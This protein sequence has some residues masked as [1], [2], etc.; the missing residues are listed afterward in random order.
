MEQLDLIEGYYK[1]LLGFTEQINLQESYKFDMEM[2]GIISANLTADILSL[3][4]GQK[5]ME[6]EIINRPSIILGEKPEEFEDAMKNLGKESQDLETTLNKTSEL[7]NNV[8]KNWTV[9]NDF[10]RNSERYLKTKNLKD[11]SSIFRAIWI[12]KAALCREGHQIMNQVEALRSFFQDIRARARNLDHDWGKVFIMYNNAMLKIVNDEGTKELYDKMNEDMD[13][14]AK[15]KDKATVFDW[16]PSIN[17]TQNDSQTYS[18]W[19]G[20][21]IF[22]DINNYTV[23]LYRTYANLD[24]GSMSY[25]GMMNNLSARFYDIKNRTDIDVAVGDRDIDFFVAYE[26]WRNVLDAFNAS[27]KVDS[28]FFRYSFPAFVM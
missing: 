9:V 6:R 4:Q 21:K 28:T 18:D 8:N 17:I 1:V 19:L 10:I 15:K 24:T 5:M 23:F 12:D 16:L 7:I 27:T 26:A 3:S 14:I 11:S 13:Y 25:D 22:K 2:F 20:N